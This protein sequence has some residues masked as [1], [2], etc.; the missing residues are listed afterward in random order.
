MNRYMLI[1]GG[2]DKKGIVYGLTGWIK[3][4]GLNIEDSSMVMLRR[5]FSVIMILTAPD[6]VDE[7]S[8]RKK[9]G[10]FSRKTGMTV[11]VVSIGEKDA[12][13]PAY[14]RNGVIVSINGADKPGIVNYI[15]GIL[16]RAGANITDLETK[17]TE[18]VRP[19]VYY[20]FIE[21]QLPAAGSLKK[22]ETKLKKAAKKLG[23]HVSVSRAETSVL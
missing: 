10:E 22:L 18:K 11:N 4:L 16:F 14:G 13:E 6:A 17:S 19:H 8:L 15:T 9:A 7:S 5:T 21:A 20:M 1:A 12:A 2:V 3:K 23:V